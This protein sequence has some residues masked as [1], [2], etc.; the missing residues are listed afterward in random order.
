MPASRS[1]RPTD[2]PA[3]A[4]V[5]EASTVTLL[6][7]LGPE[8]VVVPAVDG[9]PLADA[10][11]TLRDLELDAEVTSRAFSSDVPAGAVISQ[12]PGG[13]AELLPGESV[14]LTLSDGPEPV[15]LPNVRGQLL[16]EARGTLTDL[17]FE[18]EVEERGGFGAFLNPG[19]VFDQDPAP[20][21]ERI[22]GATITLF[23]YEG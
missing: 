21:A 16:E 9:Q 22:P 12:G 14:E 6:V 4:T 13:G 11:A 5:D 15:E 19:R 8:P 3:G 23:A 18:V 17:G 10:Q 20:G 7:S 1:S 2:P